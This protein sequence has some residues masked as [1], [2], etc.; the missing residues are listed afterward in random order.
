MGVGRTAGSSVSGSA[1]AIDRF[2]FAARAAVLVARRFGF[3][4]RAARVVL[5]VRFT[6]LPFFDAIRS[7]SLYNR[8]GVDYT[9]TDEIHAL[10]RSS[11]GRAGRSSGP[12]RLQRQAE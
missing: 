3:A 2:V 1:L 4:V 11:R 7:P 12:S 9:Q 8:L 10:W 5:F 6:A